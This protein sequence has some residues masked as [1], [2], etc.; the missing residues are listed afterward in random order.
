MDSPSRSSQSTS[1]Q[2]ACPDRSVRDVASHKLNSY[3]SPVPDPMALGTDA[4]LHPWNG[5]QAYAFLPFAIIKKVL[6][7]LRLSQ[8]CELT[9]IAP[10]WPQRDWFPDLLELWSDVPVELPKRKD[11]LRKPLMHHFKLSMPRLTA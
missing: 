6:A 9:L 1:S 4:F 7:K 10:F 8:N 11:L 3:Y 2:M 5:L